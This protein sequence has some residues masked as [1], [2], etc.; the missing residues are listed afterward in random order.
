MTPDARLKP[1]L[2][3]LV[4]GAAGVV[5]ASGGVLAYVPSTVVACSHMPNTPVVLAKAAYVIDIASQTVIFEKAGNAQLPLASLT[6]LMTVD[7]ALEI[8]GGKAEVLITQE[9]LTPEGESGLVKG[10]RWGAEALAH[11]SLIESSNDGAHALGLASEQ[12]LGLP[13]NGFVDAMNRRARTLGLTQTYFLNDTGLDQTTTTAGAYGSAR[14]VAR[15]I[16]TLG[17][18]EPAV[19]ERSAV[20]EWRFKSLSGKEHT[21]KNTALMATLYA[22]AIASKTGYTDLAGGNMAFL[23]EPIPGRPVAIA[24]LGSTREGRIADAEELA[25][26]AKSEVTRLANCNGVW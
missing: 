17:I 24:V 16:A 14:D 22:S 19:V 18:R 9:S 12:A 26:F 23:F 15:L 1:L 4:L 6:K 7:T 5:G 3:G 21:A 2:I 11:F 25:N 20:P 13:E 10:E 8:L